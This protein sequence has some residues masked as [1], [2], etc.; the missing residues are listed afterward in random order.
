MCIACRTDRRNRYGVNMR[1]KPSRM[2]ALGW[3][4][5]MGPI[6]ETF[7]DVVSEFLRLEKLA[8]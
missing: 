1:L 4:P 8:A 2:D 6:V 5:K 3:K 7:N